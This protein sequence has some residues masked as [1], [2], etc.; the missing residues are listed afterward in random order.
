[1]PSGSAVCVLP[2]SSC[3]NHVDTGCRIVNLMTQAMTVAMSGHSIG[4]DLGP[5]E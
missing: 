2:P 1:M 4:C 5:P 3:S